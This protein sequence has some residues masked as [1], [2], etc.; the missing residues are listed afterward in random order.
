MAY[1]NYVLKG[2]VNINGYDKET[3]TIRYSVA[4]MNAKSG[5]LLWRATDLEYKTVSAGRKALINLNQAARV[6]IWR[7]MSL[8]RSTKI[9]VE[10][11]NTAQ[12]LVLLPREKPVIKGAPAKIEKTDAPEKKYAVVSVNGVWTIKEFQVPKLMTKEEAFAEFMSKICQ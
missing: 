8:P 11:A 9:R 12:A 1:T 7:E 5:S 6:V 2:V 4:V 10:I 3:Q